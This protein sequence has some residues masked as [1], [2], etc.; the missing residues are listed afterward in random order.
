MTP[1]KSLYKSFII[2]IGIIFITCAIGT[3][4]G[5][6]Y[7][8]LQKE[9]MYSAG[10]LAAIKSNTDTLIKR[11]TPVDNTIAISDIGK[12]IDMLNG[13]IDK[14]DG[15]NLKMDKILRELRIV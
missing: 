12:K 4:F 5:N 13:K 2:F 7:G 15:L 14:M 1:V 8:S 3:Y 9:G 6:V 11:P 10:E